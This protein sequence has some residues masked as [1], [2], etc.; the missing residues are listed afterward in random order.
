MTAKFHE[1]A[2]NPL[3]KVRVWQC[4][5][6]LA[7]AEPRKCY[8]IPQQWIAQDNQIEASTLKCVILSTSFNQN[9][10]L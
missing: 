10:M 9:Q 3:H 8:F 4:T 1:D 6:T 5:Y 2:Y 7:R